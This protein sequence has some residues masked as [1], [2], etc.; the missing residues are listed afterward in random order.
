MRLGILSEHLKK[1]E[2]N[3]FRAVVFCIVMPLA[4]GLNCL[5]GNDIVCTL[6]YVY[7]VKVALT[8]VTDGEIIGGATLTLRD[9]VHR[10]ILR[11]TM[12][13]QY[14]GAGERAGTYDLTIEAEGYAPASRNLIIVMADACHVN[15][16]NLSI[17]LTPAP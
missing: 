2:V 10:E 15:P 7:G 1:C 16:V 17:E 3:V 4:F 9:G 5:P 14:V 12:P 11:E 13:G 6:Q 8:D